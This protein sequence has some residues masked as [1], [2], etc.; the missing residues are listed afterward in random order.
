MICLL[1]ILLSATGVISAQAGWPHF[2]KSKDGSL[3]SYETYGTG[4][5]TLIFVHGWS[6]DARYWRAQVPNFSEKHRVVL[7]DLAGHGHSSMTRSNYTMKAFGEDVRAVT[8]AVGD[9][10]VILIG[11]SM[12]GEV[13]VEAARLMPKRVIG[14]IGVD[15]LQN[16]EQPFTRE[17][18]D[19]M[20]DPF[21]KD[22]QAATR[23]FVKAMISSGC[24]PALR[25]WIVSDMSAAPSAVGIS[26][27]TD[28]MSMYLTGA[29]A[30][31]FDGLKIPVITVG[32]DMWPVNYEANRKHMF[33][34]DAIILKGTDHFLMMNRA[35]EFNKALEEAI[36]RV[37]GK[38][39][40]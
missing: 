18:F 28:L 26:A 24:D 31:L 30:K 8:Q 34:Y 39:A 5:P 13:I 9:K 25:E 1:T 3:I 22:F 10:R 36:D 33:S 17:D 27:S 20:L 15:S 6:C 19:N 40:E 21:K 14:L 7:I 11:H 29:L 4:E 32:A 16:V 2:V 35:D 38:S 37:A 23:N 12:G